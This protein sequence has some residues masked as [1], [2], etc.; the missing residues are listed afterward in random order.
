MPGLSRRRRR[1]RRRT[2]LALLVAVF[3]AAIALVV[4]GFADVGSRSGPYERAVDRSFAVQA[5]VV[6]EQS[7]RSSEQLAR[8]LGSLTSPG[9]QRL[10]LQQELDGLVADTEAAYR[11]ALDLATPPPAAGAGAALAAAMGDRARAM[12]RLRGAVDGLLGSAPLPVVRGPGAATTV[13]RPAGLGT[14]QAA[15]GELAAVGTELVHADGVYATLRRAFSTQPG[16]QRLPRSVWVP[17]QRAWGS[18]SVGGLVAQL[19]GAP[20]LAPRHRLVLVGTATGLRPAPLPPPP[21]GGIT[22]VSVVPP[23]RWLTVTTVVA[24][25]GNVAEQGSVVAVTLH[26]VGQQG[27]R[28]AAP[29]ARQRLSIPPGGTVAVEL[30]RLAVSPGATYGLTLS[31]DAPAAQ[32]D[33]SG[34]VQQLT[35]E[36]APTGSP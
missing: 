23:T 26:L 16:G 32:A 5:R 18:Q 2:G 24:N 10:V 8:L 14:T 30:G 20:A 21:A 28:G 25:L 36:V 35:V 17:D 15:T 7:N 27:G 22:G 6:V 3:G 1:G 33:R 12:S 9:V 4:A 29:S 13:G 31:V 11:A 34:L 19:A